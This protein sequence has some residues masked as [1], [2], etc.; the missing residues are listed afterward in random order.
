MEKLFLLSGLML[1]AGCAD[2]ALLGHENTHYQPI[3]KKEVDVYHGIVP[4]NC[5]QI[6]MTV[7]TIS[8]FSGNLKK[9][10]DELREEA[11]EIG[12]NYVNIETYKY[13]AGFFSSNAWHMTGTI[14]R[15][16]K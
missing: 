15:C 1:L 6:G 14:Y 10:I 11:A 4:Q 2:T 16:Q 9:E 8:P 13:V 7:L 12:G 5:Q 3:A